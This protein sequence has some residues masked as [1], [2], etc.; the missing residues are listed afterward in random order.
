MKNPSTMPRWSSSLVLV[1]LLSSAEASAQGRDWVPDSHRSGA[2]LD[3]YFGYADDIAFVAPMVGFANIGVTEVFFIDVHLPWASA[4]LEAAGLTADPRFVAGLGH[5]GVTFR[6]APRHGPIRWWIGGGLNAPMGRIEDNA[7]R[8]ALGLASAATVVYDSQLWA[9]GSLPVFLTWG[10]DGRAAGDRPLGAG[11]V[12]GK[13]HV[14]A[15]A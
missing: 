14:H 8:G 5:P 7:W 12:D 9:T 15:V 2:G 13:E 4:D 10:I 6:Y 1:G 3:A 11:R